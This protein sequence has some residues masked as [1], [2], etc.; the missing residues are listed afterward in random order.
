[1][2]GDGEPHDGR[3]NGRRDGQRDDQR[4]PAEPTR[5]RR[6]FE[7]SRSRLLFVERHVP[8]RSMNLFAGVDRFILVD[9][10]E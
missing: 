7:V 3:C 4:A 8:Q 6:L 2:I 10:F 1:V 9:S 5:R